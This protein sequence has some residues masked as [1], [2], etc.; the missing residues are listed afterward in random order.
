MTK[1]SLSETFIVRSR[2]KYCQD[3]PSIYYY[4]KTP[5]YWEDPNSSRDLFAFVKKQV[6]RLCSDIYLESSPGDFHNISFNGFKLNFKGYKPRLYKNSFPMEISAL[7]TC[8]CKKT[9]WAFPDNIDSS[10]PEVFFKRSR[11]KY[12]KKFDF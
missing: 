2:C 1:I 12:P 9:F 11:Y 7:L 4:Y 8:K 10:R 5:F 3:S 6:S